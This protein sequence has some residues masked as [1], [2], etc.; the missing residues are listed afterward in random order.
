MTGLGDNLPY[1]VDF[2]LGAVI[3]GLITFT[4]ITIIAECCGD[5]NAP[6]PAPLLTVEE[7]TNE[8][9]VEEAKKRLYMK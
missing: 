3:G 4:V 8:E 6:S 7:K 1:M 9:Q 2:I 5:D